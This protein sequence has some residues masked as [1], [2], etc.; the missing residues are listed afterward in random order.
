M[1]KYKFKYITT[2]KNLE[3]I[4]S[5]LLVKLSTYNQ[6]MTEKRIA[7]F[8]LIQSN[9]SYIDNR[10]FLNISYLLNIDKPLE[11]GLSYTESVINMIEDF[12]PKFSDKE[13]FDLKKSLQDEV[14]RKYQ[15]N[16]FDK[17]ENTNLA[18]YYDT[19]SDF[20]K[21]KMSFEDLCFISVKHKLTT[22]LFK[23]ACKDAFNRIQTKAT[24]YLDLLDNFE[25]EVVNNINNYK[26]D[27]L[28][29]NYKLVVFALL[30]QT[31]TTKKKEFKNYYDSKINSLETKVEEE[32]IHL[33]S[34][35]IHYDVAKDL[36]NYKFNLNQLSKLTLGALSLIGCEQYDSDLPWQ[37][38]QRFKIQSS[39]IKGRV[40]LDMHESNYSLNKIGLRYLSD[41]NHNS[42]NPL[43]K[44]EREYFEEKMQNTL[45]NQISN[46]LI[47]EMSDERISTYL[48]VF[49]YNKIYIDGVRITEIEPLKTFIKNDKTNTRVQQFAASSILLNAIVE[50]N[51]YIT[52]LR[53]NEYNNK[54]VTDIVPI[55]INHNKSGYM[56][57]QNIFKRIFSFLF[58]VQKNYDNKEIKDENIINNY[59]N[60]I[61]ENIKS[62][63]RKYDEL[64][65][66]N[67]EI[68]NKLKNDLNNVLDLDKSV[69]ND[70][71][72]NTN[73]INKEI[74]VKKD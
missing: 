19:L 24:Y 34:D 69:N 68:N 26:K 13:L 31:I 52:T 72:I 56:Q 10:D 14:N 51:H 35:S 9:T 8:D 50:G 66:I 44:K 12:T 62:F 48:G 30:E 16:E 41:L 2:N 54:L 6:I 27:G 71:D 43:T 29:D 65:N 64:N 47:S 55:H 33:L 67:Q 63:E 57:T 22:P 4:K 11:T 25:K 70:L 21:D 46:F 23:D 3:T 58:N 5:T 40:E 42:N 7:M 74:E 61:R 60:M 17:D 28:F 49:G 32:D 73:S 1:P 53:F 39:L 18:K 20:S 37:N 45:A 38:E 15:N 36:T 59:N